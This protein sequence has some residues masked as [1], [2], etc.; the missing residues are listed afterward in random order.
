MDAFKAS[1]LSRELIIEGIVVPLLLLWRQ[2]RQQQ[3]L[4]D[5]KTIQQKSRLWVLLQTTYFPC[6]YYN[7]LMH[8]YI[9]QYFLLHNIHLYM[10]QHLCVNFTEFQKLV[11]H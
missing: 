6:L 8:K 11:L 9:S 7:Q 3:Q 5:Y 10:F 4:Q 1:G 2:W